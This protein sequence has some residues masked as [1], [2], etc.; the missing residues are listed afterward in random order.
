MKKLLVLGA[1]LLLAACGGGNSVDESDLRETINEAKHRVCLP[2]ELDVQDR[3]SDDKAFTAHLGAPEIKLLKRLANGKRA[4]E[5]AIKQMEALVRAGLYK[6]DKE[7]KVGQGEQAIRY[8]V[9][10]LTERGEEEIK[11]GHHHAALLCV[12]KLKVK[13]INYF[14]EP[15]A[16]NGVI[17]TNVSYEAKIQPEKWANALLKEGQYKD[18]HKN[19]STK[20]VTLM[21]TSDGWRDVRELHR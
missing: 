1:T 16:L 20:T 17:V 7:Q 8:A 12:G 15:T 3:V 6:A 5:H 10:T 2:F 18:L 14:T 19:T 9:Y 13:K 11:R 21:K 4:N